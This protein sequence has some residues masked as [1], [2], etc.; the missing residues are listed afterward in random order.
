MEGDPEGT[1]SDTS[2]SHSHS[3]ALKERI[4]GV[5][6]KVGEASKIAVKK[7][8]ELGNKVVDSDITKDIV[9]SA[10]HVGDE[11]KQLPSKFSTS[12]EKKREEF[13]HKVAEAKVAKAEADDAREKELVGAMKDSQLISPESLSKSINSDDLVTLSRDEYEYLVSRSGRKS[14]INQSKANDSNQTVQSEQSNVTLSIEL[15][16]SV[17]DIL[18]TLGVTVVFA[19]IIV[20]VDYYFDA[21]PQILAGIPINLI[22]WSLGTS[23][24]CYYMLHRLSISGSFLRVPK[25]LRIQTAIGVG[26]ATGLTILLNTDT[27]AITNIWGWTAIVALTAMLLSGIVRG[28][29][30]SLISIFRFRKSKN[31]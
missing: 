7:T 9:S 23:V 3:D 28:I 22:T 25:G 6:Q 2:S 27:I 15:S 4:K 17:N 5:G 24:W 12:V 20:G 13:K 31:E 11:V 10:R 19:G 29:S 26:L 18:Q 21:N 16:R 30:G 8:E 14:S 1:G